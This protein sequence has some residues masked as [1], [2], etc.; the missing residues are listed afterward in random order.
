MKNPKLRNIILSILLMTITSTN[1]WSNYPIGNTFFWW[2]F[3]GITLILLIVNKKQFFDPKDNE[4]LKVLYWY[5]AWNIICILRGYFIAENYWEWKNLIETGFVLLLPLT[6]NIST[7]RFVIQEILHNWLKFALPAFFVFLFVLQGE[8]YGRYLAPITLLLLF[9]FALEFK[10][11][12]LLSVFTLIV[13]MGGI[14]ARSNIVKFSV[15]FLIGGVYPFRHFINIKLLEIGRQILLIAPIVFF[16]LG[17]TGVFNIFK[18]DEY[19][20]GS[21]YKTEIVK[22]EVVQLDLKADTRTGIYEEVLLSAIKNDYIIFG[23]TPARG[24]DS[25]LF[26]YQLNEILK[27]GKKERFINEVSILNIFTW[28]GIIGVV[29]YFLIFFRASYLA[30]NKSN[31]YFMR[32]VGLF[33]AFR[34]TYAWVEDFTT[35]DLY[36]FFLWLMIGMCFSKPFRSMTENE[37]L[38][39]IKGIFYKKHMFLARKVI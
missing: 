8:A 6:I 22:G 20:K 34:W 1:Q 18:L 5:L 35:F 29:L 31:N 23:R 37:M 11:K 33:V 16:I 17:V 15:S 38:L 7:N 10:L 28:T 39:W 24:N 12:V 14:D 3:Y 25:S 13:L 30:I 26:G 4:S 32:L 21:Y 36:Y 27:T 9:F 2:A 19:I